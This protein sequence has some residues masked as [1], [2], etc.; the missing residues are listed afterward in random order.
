MPRRI[1]NMRRLSAYYLQT[2]ESIYV[3]KNNI[4]ESLSHPRVIENPGFS[5]FWFVDINTPHMILHDGFIWRRS[6]IKLSFL[7]LPNVTIVQGNHI[8]GVIILRKC[9]TRVLVPTWSGSVERSNRAK[10]LPK[11][12]L[13]SSL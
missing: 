2:F 8:T 7:W 11:D 12:S 10:A 1:S 13:E 3:Q 6:L 5:T 9:N 4:T